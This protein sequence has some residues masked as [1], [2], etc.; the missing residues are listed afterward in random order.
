MYGQS[1]SDMLTKAQKSTD[2]FYDIL[3]R[4]VSA[5]VNARIT[6]SKKKPVPSTSLGAK[7]DVVKKLI[8]ARNE[9]KVE[10]G[11]LLRDS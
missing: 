2:F 11:R 10:P 8:W 9:R 5:L 3:S 1:F 4:Y 6:I 7:L